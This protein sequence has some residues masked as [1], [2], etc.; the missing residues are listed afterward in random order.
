M[1]HLET[2]LSAFRARIL[3]FI[4][5][6]G[7]HDSP[8]SFEY[9]DDGLLL[10]NNG[11]IAGIG[12][13][14]EMLPTLPPATTIVTH[15][16]RLIL[17]GF[18][19][20]HIHYAQT[21]VIASAGKQLLDWLEHYTFPVERKFAAAEHALEVAEF[22]CDELLRNGTTSALVYPTVHKASVEA[23]FS[24]CAKRNLR[25]VS[26][27]VLMDRNCPGY[28]S[29]T[30]Q[31]AYNDTSA[32]IEKWDGQYRLN[33][34][35]TPRFAITSTESQLDV[36]AQ[37]AGEH[38]DMYI[39]SHLAEHLDE[40]A[41]VRR[42]FPWSRSYL[43][44]YDRYG[45]LRNRAVYAHCIHL[46]ELD[47]RRMAASGA[48]AAFCP[49]SNLYLG[50]GL[51]NIDRADAARMPFAIATDVGGGTSFSMLR[52]LGEAYK[53]AQ[54]CQQR[55]TPLRAFYL[56]T[57]GGARIL[58]LDDKIGNFM[59]GNEA[60]FIVLDPYATPLTARRS[61]STNNLSEWLCVLMTLG[62]DR[63]IAETYIL[64]Q[65]SNPAH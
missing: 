11:L 23:F 15:R 18:V 13:A 17:P 45:L 26:G 28:L 53:V 7:D 5:D 40:V 56:A 62:D 36:I 29:D 20:T 43:D 54:M 27:K 16:D 61:R 64:G 38:P 41:L 46:D 44:V 3:H 12:P 50:S 59:P 35:I 2:G 14:A 31:S 24:V 19:D 55:L 32:L 25:M 34:A 52:T 30:A 9:F 37:L 33:Y 57:L 47:V 21:D 6:P 65:A 8:A 10:V 42:L 1:T 39:Q 63:A 48:A 49:T 51:F 60:D 4:S 22:F 58:G